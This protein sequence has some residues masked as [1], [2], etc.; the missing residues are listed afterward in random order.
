M[1]SAS[2]PE[3]RM[4]RLF[5]LLSM[6]MLVACAQQQPPPPPPAPPPAPP[7]QAQP[8]V[9]HVYFAE[10]SATLTPEARQI[11][12][13]AAAAAK[14]APPGP[15]QVVGY[16]DT[17][18]SAALN[19][20]LSRQRAQTVANL[21]VQDGVPQGQIQVSGAGE[22]PGPNPAESRRVEVTVGGGR[23]GGA[24]RGA[25]FAAEH[26]GHRSSH[27]E[28]APPIRRWR[29]SAALVARRRRQA[30]R[31]DR[32][33]RAALPGPFVERTGNL[34]CGRCA[35]TRR[36]SRMSGRRGHA[37]Y[38]RAMGGAGLGD[39]PGPHWSFSTEISPV[40]D[41]PRPR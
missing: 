12:E 38:R 20:R 4:K 26:G 28:R 18:G 31:R 24:A 30:G 14:A 40:R 3:G 11:V 19:Q 1:V 21:L 9:F 13:A 39:A 6:L 17:T 16:T 22:Q 37:R 32:L 33:N 7:P 5:L 27:I 8:S 35:R 34:C 10:G 41:K 29:R 25:S 15:V 2:L 36:A 23:R